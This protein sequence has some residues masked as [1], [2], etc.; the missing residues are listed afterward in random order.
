MCEIGGRFFLFFF[1]K[2]VFLLAKP[3]AV[4]VVYFI[5]GRGLM[6]YISERVYN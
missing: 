6:A 3:F 4:C 1:L 5:F 2:I